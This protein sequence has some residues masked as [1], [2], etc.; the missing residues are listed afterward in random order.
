[1]IERLARMAGIERRGYTDMAIAASVAAALDGTAVIGAIESAAGIIGR[2]LA[3]ASVNGADAGYFDAETLLAIGRAL[4]VAG[5][6]AALIVPGKPL[7]QLFDFDIVPGAL[8]PTDPDYQLR[9]S[10]EGGAAAQTDKAI[11]VRYSMTQ[12]GRGAGVLQNARQLYK[13]AAHTERVLA[14]ELS[15]IVGAVMPLPNM[16]DDKA[17]ALKATVKTLKGKTAFVETTLQGGAAARGVGLPQP[18]QDY[19]QIRI[20]PAP[21]KEWL[22][23]FEMIERMIYRALGIPLTMTGNL[24][25]ALT[26]EA[27][28]QF[29]TLAVEPLARLIEAAAARRGLSVDLSFEPAA[30]FDI[31]GRARAWGVLVSN[32]YDDELASEIVGFPTDGDIDG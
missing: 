22:D 8:G 32:G 5:E 15:G 12:T 9:Y 23:A 24:Q 7:V 30:R 25:Q 6:Y 11:L 2:A 31:A 17:D 4:V 20:G 27:L 18:K 13:I 28:R 3:T 1:M 26:R 14:E 10:V 21:R 16:A 19:E 29:H